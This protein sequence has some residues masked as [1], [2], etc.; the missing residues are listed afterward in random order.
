LDSAAL[1]WT[2]FEVVDVLF[3]V[4]LKHIL[5][6]ENGRL[7]FSQKSDEDLER[8]DPIDD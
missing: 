2:R 3:D 7:P 4:E 5:K 6:S 1:A 8:H